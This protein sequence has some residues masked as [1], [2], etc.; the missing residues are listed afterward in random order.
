MAEALK[1]MVSQKQLTS[2]GENKYV[3]GPPEKFGNFRGG[4]LSGFKSQVSEY[5]WNSVSLFS[6]TRI[7][8]EL[9]IKSLKKKWRLFFFFFFFVH[10]Y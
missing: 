4:G 2:K 10:L 8:R 6:D 3:T 7:K 9:K 5:A 1:A